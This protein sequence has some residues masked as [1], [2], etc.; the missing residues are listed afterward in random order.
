MET[1]HPREPH[2]KTGEAW[3]TDLLNICLMISYL[4]VWCFE[5]PIFLWAFGAR[6]E[7]GK[8]DVADEDLR[9]NNFEANNV[10]STRMTLILPEIFLNTKK[11]TTIKIGLEK[12]INFD[13]NET[14]TVRELFT[15][16]LVFLKALEQMSNFPF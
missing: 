4:A 3:E 8:I 16:F 1:G 14:T 2:P 7:D 10:H 15:F 5:A 9:R 11:R 13:R 6:V 12:S